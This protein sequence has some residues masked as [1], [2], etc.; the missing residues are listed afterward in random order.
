MGQAEGERLMRGYRLGRTAHYVRQVVCPIRKRW[1]G[2]YCLHVR[3]DSIRHDKYVS[4]I[5]STERCM[6][7]KPE[8]IVSIKISVVDPSQRRGWSHVV[9]GKWYANEEYKVEA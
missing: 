1:N 4:Y 5:K 3:Y 9:K 2:T 7:T 6:L 8:S